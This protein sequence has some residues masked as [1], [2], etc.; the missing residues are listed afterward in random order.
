MK[1]TLLNELEAIDDATLIAN[2]KQTPTL[3]CFLRRLLFFG[4]FRPKLNSPAHNAEARD[5]WVV[6]TL[7]EI[8]AREGFANVRCERA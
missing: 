4:N 1:L 8:S 5:G 2:K 7:F 3:R 6:W